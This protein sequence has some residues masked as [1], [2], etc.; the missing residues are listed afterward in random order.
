M[1]PT[2]YTSANLAYLPQALVL[3]ESVRASNPRCRLVLVLVDELPEDDIVLGHLA[4]FDEVLV[5]RDLF[6]PDFSQ[7]IFGHDVVEACTAVKGRALQVLLEDGDVVY[8]DPDMA[9]FGALDDFFAE[10]EGA[11]VLLTP[12]VTAPE[13]PESPYIGD[14]LSALRHGTYNFGMYGVAASSEGRAFADWWTGRLEQHCIDDVPNGLFTDQ[15]WGDLVPSLFPSAVVCR[16]PGVNVASWN[17]HQRPFT[18]SVD[19]DH[20]VDGRPLV[21]Y[22]FTKAR[23]LGLQVSRR[24]M[25]DNPLVADLWRWYLERLEFHTAAVPGRRWAYADSVDGV[26][27]E[28]DRRRLFRSRWGM[29]GLPTDPFALRSDDEWWAEA[30]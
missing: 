7:W 14:E 9:V 10:L 19:G 18:M 17:L 8:L 11:S 26:P 28:L 2:L 16:H 6:G 25:E 23:D 21:T 27:I 15:R 22:H 4:S 29:P 30:R 13:P 24:K 3:L 12:H 5:A 1:S 20:L